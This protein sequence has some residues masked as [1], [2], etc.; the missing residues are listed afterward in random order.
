MRW[1]Q[2]IDRVSSMRCYCVVVVVQEP[3][4][5]QEVISSI[6]RNGVALK[7]ASIML[8]NNHTS[9]YLSCGCRCGT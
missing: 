4:E 5:L 7:G 2:L 1:D 8:I 9:R 3:L 6:S